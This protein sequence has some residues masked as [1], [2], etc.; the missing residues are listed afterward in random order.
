MRKG[1][2]ELVLPFFP[3]FFSPSL[4]PSTSPFLPPQQFSQEFIAL[5]PLFLLT[6]FSF[7]NHTLPSFPTIYRF[8]IIVFVS[9]YPV[10]F[11]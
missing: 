10:K 11:F 2:E 8:I 6:L 5:S 7:L 3:S 4:F 1:C 9:T